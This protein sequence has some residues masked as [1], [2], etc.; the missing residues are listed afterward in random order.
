MIRQY[1][2]QRSKA[3][4]FHGRPVGTVPV[5]T[6]VYIQDARPMRPIE[7]P[8]YRAP[9]IV[10]AWKPREYHPCRRG[11]PP[12]TYLRGGDLAIVRCLRTGR[13]ATVADWLLIA[14]LGDN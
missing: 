7:R 11:A 5:G 14:S 8:I 4:R 13:R 10:E 12:T 6:I 9:W 2:P 1:Y 3:E